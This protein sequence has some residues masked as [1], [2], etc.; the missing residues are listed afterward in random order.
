MIVNFIAA[1][2]RPS[3]RSLATV[4][5]APTSNTS[6]PAARIVKRNNGEEAA[7]H[8]AVLLNRSPLITRTP[9]DFEKAYYAYQARIERAL[10]NPLPY[11]FYFKPNSPLEI[12]FDKEELEREKEAFGKSGSPSP[13]VKAEVETSD[14][15]DPHALPLMEAAQE[16]VEKPMP[17]EHES[18]R[19]GDVKSLNRQGQRN[20]YLVVLS[21][22]SS[23]K[24]SW[25]FPQT[26]VTKDQ[27]LFDVSSVLL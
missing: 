15:S 24:E 26:P 3:T 12:R 5:E 25:K 4:T 23:G 1:Q 2:S 6:S 14:D 20:I 21:K 18:D 11:D 7:I 22:D 9:T 17:R 27:N 8:A 10:H 13:R 19:T 16:E